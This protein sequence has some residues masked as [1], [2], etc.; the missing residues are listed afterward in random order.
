MAASEF[1]HLRCQIDARLEQLLPRQADD[2]VTLAMRDCLLSGGKR[3][4]PC[5]L[6]LTARGWET[7]RRL[8]LTWGVPWR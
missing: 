7:T 1:S 6:I 4:R 3:V 8:C 2:P 5:L